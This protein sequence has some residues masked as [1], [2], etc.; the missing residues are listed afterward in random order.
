M[1]KFDIILTVCPPWGSP[2][3]PIGL[4]YLAS[5]L[6]DKKLNPKVLDLNLEV[7]DNLSNEGFEKYWLSRYCKHWSDQKLFCE[8]I[9]NIPEQIEYCVGRLLSFGTEIIGFSINQSNRNFSVV[10]AQELKKEMK[11]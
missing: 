2:S 8:F 9:K 4:A 10:I 1:E 3:V 11:S 5:Y 7:F 6:K